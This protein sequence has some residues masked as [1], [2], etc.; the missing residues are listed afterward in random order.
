[1]I[2]GFSFLGVAATVILLIVVSANMPQGQNNDLGGL[3]CGGSA[4]LLLGWLVLAAIYSQ[5]GIRPTEIT[6]RYVRLTGVNREFINALE[7]DRER[8][9]QEEDDYRRKWK[10]RRRAEREADE[11]DRGNERLEDKR[12]RP[13]PPKAGPIDDDLERRALG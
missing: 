9:R 5:R 12:E 6:D 8:D 3:V 10:E 2:V 7:D 1:M 4:V 11:R 13:R